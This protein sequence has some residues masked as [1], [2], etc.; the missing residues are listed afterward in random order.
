MSVKI[1]T[2]CDVI[3]DQNEFVYN[4]LKCKQC[5]RKEANARYQKNK[6][7]KK[8][9]KDPLSTRTHKENEILKK[10]V[11]RLTNELNSRINT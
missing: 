3:K 9:K 11:E 6:H 5:Y 10:E 7:I 8:E 1:C 2:S 4:R